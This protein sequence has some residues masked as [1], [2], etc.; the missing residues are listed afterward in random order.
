MDNSN[1]ISSPVIELKNVYKYYDD[2]AVLKNVSFTVGRGETK[3]ILGG[4]GSGKSTIL[5]IIVGLEKVD[6]GEVWV[7]GENIT[8]YAEAPLMKIR[9]QIGMVFQEGALFDSLSVGDNVG[10]R[11]YEQGIL[12]DDELLKIIKQTLGFVDMEDALEKMPSELSGGRYAYAP[13]N[14]IHGGKPTVPLWSFCPTA[15]PG[16]SRS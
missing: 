4:S 10:Y 11:L 3:I 2:T 5:K 8:S 13:K 12:N 14:S 7:E 1:Q 15:C 9:K 6:E 16:R